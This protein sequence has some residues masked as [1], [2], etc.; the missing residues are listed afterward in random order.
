MTATKYI[1]RK[2]CLQCSAINPMELLRC[3]QCNHLFVGEATK[4]EKEIY[5]KKIERLTKFK[6]EVKEEKEQE[7]D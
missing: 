6:K 7:E 5:D 1:L 3:S 4:E 2:L